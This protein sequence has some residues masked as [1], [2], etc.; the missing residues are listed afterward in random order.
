VT[1]ARIFDAGHMV[2]LTHATAVNS[3]IDRHIRRTEEMAVSAQGGGLLRPPAA[4]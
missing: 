1:A 2:P 4:A 3:L